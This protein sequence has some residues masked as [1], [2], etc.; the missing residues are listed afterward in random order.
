VA[1]SDSDQN[2]NINARWRNNDW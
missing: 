2:I 1:Q